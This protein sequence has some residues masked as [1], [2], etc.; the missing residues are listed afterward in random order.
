MNKF[1]KE[2]VKHFWT[3]INLKCLIKV[4]LLELLTKLPELLAY[5][6]Q[7]SLLFIIKS[8]IN[9]SIM[10]ILYNNKILTDIGLNPT[11]I[12]VNSWSFLNFTKRLAFFYNQ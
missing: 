11:F 5:M 9:A 4:K 7:E 3:K 1:S 6:S 8:A 2:I 10:L 12:K